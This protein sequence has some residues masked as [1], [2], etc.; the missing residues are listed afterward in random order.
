MKKLLSIIVVSLLLCGNGYANTPVEN[1]VFKKLFDEYSYCTVYYKFLARSVERIELRNDDKLFAE[2]MNKL[3]EKSEINMIFFAKKISKPANDVQKNIQRIYE[4]FLNIAGRDYSKTEILINQYTKSCENSL[5]DPEV[6]M[7][8]WDKEFQKINNN[9]QILSSKTLTCANNQ[10]YEK[11]N[12]VFGI[13]FIS[14][15]E[16]L[17]FHIKDFKLIKAKYNLNV[18]INKIRFEIS[19]KDVEQYQNDSLPEWFD[20][21]R[22]NLKFAYKYKSAIGYENDY[23][24]KIIKCELKNKGS[25]EI[26]EKLMNDQL[27]KDVQ[28]Q[29]KIN[30]I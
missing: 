29:K 20:F 6:R 18:K 1:F 5:A 7:A 16:A 8:Y 24:L 17:V 13:F 14:E 10:N 19:V 23:D 21:K 3:S 2:E 28:S 4:S 12:I 26:L 30:K 22:Y 25:L 11:K 15:F 9:G 27:Q